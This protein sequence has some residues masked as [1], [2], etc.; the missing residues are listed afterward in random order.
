M[1]TIVTDQGIVHYETHGSGPPVILLH[2]WLGSWQTWRSTMVAMARDY[3]FY[4]LD[5]WGFGDS[6]KKRERFEV[7]DFVDLVNQ[8]MDRLG[9][10]SAPIV[11]HSMGGSV[12]LGVTVKYPER[13]K[14]V[15]VVGSPVYGKEGFMPMLLPFANPLFARAIWSSPAL[16]RLGMRL[17]YAPL[18]TR[19]ESSEFYKMTAPATDVTTLESFF[20]S[21]ASL[22]RVDLRED[23]KK[24]SQPA[25]GVYGK[26]DV[27]INPRQRFTFQESLANSDVLYMPGS[28]HIPMMDEPEL[29]NEGLKKF[30][31]G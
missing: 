12:S 23:L 16:F 6:D 2:G 3:K 24:V 13:V 4:A 28:G 19:K 17:I 31:A 29:F 15:A 30:L 22:Q 26:L 25:L 1:S 21:I 11:G 14:K 20:R 27:L 9:I 7:M 8:F 5:F 10:V 18:I